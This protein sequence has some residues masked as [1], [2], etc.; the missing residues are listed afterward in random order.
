MAMSPDEQSVYKSSVENPSFMTRQQWVIAGYAVADT[1][2]ILSASSCAFGKNKVALRP[3]RKM[4][5]PPIRGLPEI[6]INVRK[7]GQPDLRCPRRRARGRD[8]WRTPNSLLLTTRPGETG[9]SIKPVEVCLARPASGPGSR[10]VRILR[11][12]R[13]AASGR[14]E[15]GRC[16]RSTAGALC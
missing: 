12:T 8:I 9:G 10:H 16:G 15:A 13:R 3:S 14:A 2:R 5:G 7:S 11:N 6:G 4:G 1:P